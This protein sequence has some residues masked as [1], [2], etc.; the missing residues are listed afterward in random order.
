MK[1]IVLLLV[2]FGVLLGLSDFAFA[3]RPRQEIKEEMRRVEQDVARLEEKLAIAK[4]RE[5]KT[6]IMALLIGQRQRIKD[7][8]QA[9]ES[10]GE[11]PAGPEPEV[12]PG[13]ERDMPRDLPMKPPMPHEPERMMQHQREPEPGMPREERPS[14]M[15]VGLS[16]GMIAGAVGA[17]GEIRFRE[18]F[19]LVSTCLRLGLGYAQGTDK[20]SLTKKMVPVS[21]DGIYRLTPEGVPGLKSYFGLGINYV[22]YNTLSTQ[23]TIGGQI[24]Y[25]AEGDLRPGMVFVEVGYG[26]LRNST[27]NE[28][29]NFTGFGVTGGYRIGL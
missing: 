6:E 24:F 23:G 25:G 14:R 13:P 20:N 11:P 7:L 3:R 28:N 16:G 22:A 18:P 26:L 5:R 10:I 27:T 19:D 21:I 8:Q 2:V 1:K 17:V 15:E 12:M 9:L 4:M 29:I